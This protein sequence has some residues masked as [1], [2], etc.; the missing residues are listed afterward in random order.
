MKRIICPEPPNPDEPVRT[1]IRKL[2]RAFEAVGGEVT[3]QVTGE[4]TG[5]VGPRP[6]SQPESLELRVLRQLTEP[7]AKAELSGRLG[8]KEISGRLNQVI[9]ILLADQTVEYTIPD[10]PNS[11]LQKYRLTAKGKNLLAT[12]SKKEGQP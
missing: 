9:R 8:H 3:G 2:D 12:L 4:V 11:R 10:K 7:L 1:V 5:E 6:E